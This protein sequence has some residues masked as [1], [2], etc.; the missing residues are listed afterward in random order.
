M[1]PK[2]FQSLTAMIILAI[3]GCS[4]EAS[5]FS[6][7]GRVLVDQRPAEGVYVV[8]HRIG[9]GNAGSV[10]GSARTSEDGTYLS[11]LPDVGSYAITC[12]WPSV[13]EREDETLEGPDRFQ[14][15]Y[16]NV[17]QPVLTVEIDGQLTEIPAIE[18]S[19]RGARRRT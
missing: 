10:T 4:E 16:Q 19:A 6:V 2:P 7:S 14:G 17:Q 1:I 5:T 11:Q 12:F 9:S 18:L 8:L 15:R 3:G 13:I